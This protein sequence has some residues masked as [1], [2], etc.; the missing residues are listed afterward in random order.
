MVYGLPLKWRQVSRR[1]Y[2]SHA[3]VDVTLSAV[4]DPPLREGAP[5]CDTRV[6]QPRIVVSTPTTIRQGAHNLCIAPDHSPF[7]EQLV[8]LS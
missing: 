2:N 8:L 7:Q 1:Y 5:S 4:F 6:R 3:L